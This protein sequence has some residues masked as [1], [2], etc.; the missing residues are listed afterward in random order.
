M[1]IT[2]QERTQDGQRSLECVIH[3]GG[4]GFREEDLPKLFEPFFTRRR[5]GTGLGLSIA[6]R[7]VEQHGGSV[8][9]ANHPE[10]GALMRVRLPLPP[11]R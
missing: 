6:Q 4:P 9:A 8:S 2:A 10:G 5:G 7:I 3:D 11:E 1:T